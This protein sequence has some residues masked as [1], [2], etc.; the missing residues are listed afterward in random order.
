MLNRPFTN[1]EHDKLLE[2]W[3]AGLPASEIAAT[4]DRTRNSILG[5]IFRVRKDMP[6]LQRMPTPQ[7]KKSTTNSLRKLNLPMVPKAKPIP[8]VQKNI[9][10]PIVDEVAPP[11]GISL[12]DTAYGQCRYILNTSR[13]V[14]DVKCCG[15]LVY[16]NS[17]WCPQH[18]AEV[19]TERTYPEKRVAR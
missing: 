12:L 15:R 11:N 2:M 10:T 7:R 17:S 8:I 19:F 6:E 4:L 16:N 18:Y 14:H 5:Y 3:R 9:Y 1:K 13:N